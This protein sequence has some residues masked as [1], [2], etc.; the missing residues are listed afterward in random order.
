MHFILPLLLVFANTG[1]APAHPEGAVEV[2]HCAFDES[3]DVNYDTWPDEWTRRTG[4]G[5]PA[6]LKIEIVD[7]PSPESVRSLQV[8]LDGGAAAIY[9]D[10][11]RVSWMFGYVVDVW[12]KTEELKYDSVFISANVVDAKETPLQSFH[13]AA[14]RQTDGWR[15]LRLGPFE[16]D[17]E[18]ADR[19]V[20]GLHVV[21]GSRADLT[22]RVL[23][24]GIWVGRVPRLSMSLNQP[25]KVYLMPA[26]IEL[27]ANVAGIDA[28]TKEI[29][30][31]AVD[32]LGNVIAA[33]TVPLDLEPAFAHGELTLDPTLREH[34]PMLGT[35]KWKPSFDE[36][37]YYRLTA[38]LRAPDGTTYR[39]HVAL[40]VIEPVPIPSDGEFGWSFTAQPA[41][42]PLRE[43]AFLIANSGVS[44]IK[45]PVWIDDQ[46]PADA[47][48]DLAD[49]VSRL[50]AQGIMVVGELCDPPQSVL[51]VFGHGTPPL[52]AEVFSAEPETWYPSVEWTLSRFGTL[53][54]WWQV[55]HDHDT[56][57]NGYPH[58]VD[59]LARIKETL[60]KVVYD[61]RLGMAWNWMADPP[62]NEGKKV[63]RFLS[64]TADPPL[65]A[66]EL[67]TYLPHVRSTQ[68]ETWTA[69][70]PL[71]RDGYP[72]EV[73]V[74]DLVERMMAA[75]MNG[76]D[77]SFLV[78]PI[79]N[80]RGLFLGDGTP[81]ELY[82]PWRTTA[83]VLSGCRYVG[84]MRLPGGSENRIFRRKDQAVMVLWNR[85][86][87]LEEL[88]LGEDAR[89]FDVWGRNRPIE[90][91]E[92]R[93]RV[94]AEPLPGFVVGVEL[95]LVQWRQSCRLESDNIPSVYGRPFLNK[96][97]FTNG[98]NQGVSG[99]ARIVAPEGWMIEPAVIPF[100]L[101][102]QEQAVQPIT[103]TLPYDATSGRQPIRIDF[104]V[105]AERTYR[106]SVFRHIDVGLGDIYLEVTTH[107]NADGELEVEQHFVNDT[108]V[109]VSFRCE[110][111]A[112]DRRRMTTTITEQGTGR[113]VT[114]FR[115]SNGQELIGKTLWL[116][117]EEIG[118]PRILNYRFR[119]VP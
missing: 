115:L 34:P 7:E 91:H 83:L 12:V 36:P 37:G 86:P 59:R 19:M 96:L 118:G 79:N 95:P 105:R 108:A 42:I 70:D 48:N 106:F 13:S 6:Y 55:G 43:L 68:H 116:R 47:T 30:F 117:A 99:T 66:S 62:D 20:L 45:Y 44:W 73:R 60:D 76:A 61:V 5:Y 97:I 27:E 90:T 110:L 14:V 88:Y 63:W 94:V 65:T 11:I 26:D 92:G 32:I 17:D 41:R 69:I 3:R 74:R 67:E 85:R 84:S 100:K 104:L 38:A 8:R 112:P 78:D 31:E 119:A 98:F 1:Q 2:Y 75:K 35:A 9:T 51:D 80:R 72:L 93:Q 77:V 24:G 107:L 25:R 89:Q 54:N 71:D 39:R 81:T 16:F 114:I 28:R 103:I 58:V 23:F 109:P 46:T 57:F 18:K 82:L 56:S 22:G 21:P 52:A 15:R 53:I 4:D 40:A 29:D 113:R 33:E 111:F 101:T 87:T 10:A 64:Y 102:E 49:F 50:V